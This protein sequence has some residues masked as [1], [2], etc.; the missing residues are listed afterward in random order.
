MS[1]FDEFWQKL[2]IDL[3]YGKS[4]K[5]LKGEGQ[6]DAIMSEGQAL[7]NVT[8]S[9]GST[10]R[11]KKDE[12]Y[13]IWDVM[14][15]DNSSDR[16]VD[17]DGRYSSNCPDYPYITTLIQRI[18]GDQVMSGKVVQARIIQRD[19]TDG[20]LDAVNTACLDAE[21]RV[22]DVQFLSPH[23]CSIIY[24]ADRIESLRP[25]LDKGN[26]ASGE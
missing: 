22:K 18:V 19:D 8:P 25:L 13:K 1:Y 20:L 14:K 26:S 9:G 24:E 23:M 11:I 10:R 7:I 12:F 15:H 5:T 16:Y 4:L 21:G 6:F 2:S 17:K 3:K